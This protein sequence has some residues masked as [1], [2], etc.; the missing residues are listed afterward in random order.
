MNACSTPRNTGRR[1]QMLP[2][3]P[4][5]ASNHGHVRAD[6]SA[7]RRRRR[8]PI[9]QLALPLRALANDAVQFPWQRRIQL[10]NGRVRAIQDAAEYESRSR[11]AV[12]R[13]GIQWL[14]PRNQFDA[15]S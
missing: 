15:I 6:P 8:W 7:S 4:V 3:L 2:T 5:A 13:D 11:N 14:D 10:H 9:A 12:T 1:P